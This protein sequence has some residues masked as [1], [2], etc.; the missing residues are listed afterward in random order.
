MTNC[1]ETFL[2]VYL[3]ISVLA[4]IFATLDL[5]DDINEDGFD[6]LMI[7]C[8]YPRIAFVVFI[9]IWYGIMWI[10][11]LNIYFMQNLESFKSFTQGKTDD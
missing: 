9:I 1:S 10:P 5:M 7:Y 11:I 4:S 8:R 6:D 2:T 3:M